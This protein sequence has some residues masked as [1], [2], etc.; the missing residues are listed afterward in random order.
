MD[1]GSI[2]NFLDPLVV[3]TNLTKEVK[4]ANGQKLCNEGYGQKGVKI[5][6]AEFLISFHVLHLGGCDIGL[7][8]QWLKTLGRNG[9]L[10]TCQC[11][12]L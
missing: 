9:T 8:V 3:A 2:H 4:V 6:G 10:P 12:S 11:S 7:R 5:Q 1:S